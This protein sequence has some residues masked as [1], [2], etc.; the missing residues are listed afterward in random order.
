M[1]RHLT[2]LI[3]A[4]ASLLSGPAALAVY[5]ADLG[6]WITRDPLGYRDGQSLYVYTRNNGI[7]NTDSTGL[8][9][10]SCE[11]GGNQQAPVDTEGPC[12]K[13]H[14]DVPPDPDPPGEWQDPFPSHTGEPITWTRERCCKI[15][16]QLPGPDKY[17][18]SECCGGVRVTCVY[19]DRIR[20]DY[21]TASSI[22]GECVQD[23]ENHHTR[24]KDC[25]VMPAI[26]C[27]PKG[28][29]ECWAY[30]EELNCI[31]RKCGGH[32]FPEI[33]DNCDSCEDNP[34]PGRCNDD[35]KKYTRDTRKRRDTACETCGLDDNTIEFRPELASP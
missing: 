14:P 10:A 3:A 7:R 8:F 16:Q 15:H 29:V 19:E 26:W 1:F 35:M 28:C 6:R 21:P 30:E 4:F 11:Q 5:N 25:S 34:D 27:C 20:K 32:G 22:I 33:F 12:G 24:C 2:V 31:A 18:S 23:H 17:G 13:N 9:C